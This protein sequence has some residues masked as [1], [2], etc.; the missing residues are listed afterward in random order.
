MNKVTGKALSL[1]L[2]LALVVSSFPA[3][4][5]SAST[6]TAYGIVDNTTNDSIYMVNGGSGNALKSPELNETWIKPSLQTNTRDDA[7]D[8]KVTAISHVS[9]D[10]LVSLD[11]ENNRD[12][13]YLKLKSKSVK[14][15]EVIAILYKATY[16]DEDGNDYTIKARKNFTVYVLDKNAP[17][18]G[19]V[20][21]STNPSK[22]PDDGKGLDDFETFAQTRNT[23]KTV[24]LY[25]AEPANDDP[26]NGNAEATFKPITVT[27]DKKGV[28][29]DKNEDV[30]DSCYYLEI[31]DGKNDLHFADANLTDLADKDVAWPTQPKSG[32]KDQLSGLY[33]LN[34]DANPF[35]VVS[36]KDL[37]NKDADYG[38][39]NVFTE[40]AGTSNVT[41]TLKKL[42]SDGTV[43][44]S[45]SDK[46]T[47]KTKIEKKVN[48]A[49]VYKNAGKSVPSTFTV[50]KSDGQ[51]RLDGV[52]D[53]LSS[54]GKN[55]KYVKVTD[56]ILDF[57]KGTESVSVGDDTDTTNTKSIVGYVGELTIGED[58]HVGTIDIKDGTVDVSGK[59]GDITTDDKSYDAGSNAT[60]GSVKIEST[61][62][63]GAIDTT[64]ADTSTDEG[65]VTIN[66]GTVGDVTTKSTVSIDGQDSD[67]NI[68]TGIVT[69]NGGTIYSDEAK[70]SIGGL[71]AKSDDGTF[72]L[73]GDNVAVKSVDLDSRNTTLQLGS[74]DEDDE[75]FTGTIPQ[76]KNATNA[77]IK[78][79]NDGT[80]A[81]IKSDLNVDTIDM[82]SD[83]Q[84]TLA[85]NNQAKTIEGDG[86]LTIPAGKLYVTE[87][88]SSTKLKLS[89]KNIAVGTTVFKAKSD[90]VSEDD[91]DCYGFTVTKKAGNTVDTFNVASLKFAGMQISGGP[92]QL[93]VGQSGTYTASAYPTGTTVPTGY[94]VE[95]DLDGGS[96]DVFALTS[97]GNT[98]TVKVNS[99]DTTFASENKT[100]LTATLYDQDGYEDD[101]Y[102][103]ATFDIAA[104]STPAFQSDTHGNVNVAQG[105]TYQFKIT[106]SDGSQPT[107]TV[108]GA[109]FTYYTVGKSGNDYFFKVTPSKTSKVG[110]CVGVYVN[111]QRIATAT[112][113]APAFTID[114]GKTLSLSVGKAYTFKVTASS[115]PSFTSANSSVAKSVS[116]SVSGN[117]Y[118]F[119]IQGVHAGTV[120]IYVDGVRCTV[121][122]VK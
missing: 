99:L 95:W 24:G 91:F 7:D 97:T 55:N 71:K 110:D 41:F 56:A 29:P 116:S 120:G 16:T 94:T 109:A 49:Q 9:G 73:E 27:T 84:L 69:A 96:S 68:T 54:D 118:Y 76:I 72:V 28:V 92:S 18:F 107:F 67:D 33:T 101:D 122:T 114:T 8:A 65:Q 22:A 37:A 12:D 104:V 77:T 47:F 26:K 105:K 36:G 93:V 64:D 63:A 83:T 62:T 70:V 11:L 75:A 6:R 60:D 82:D 2:S 21:D 111:G 90:A 4:L 115:K 58:A 31:T 78:T 74:E 44:S 121:V 112:V 89:D 79:E 80:N 45:S 14:G 23:V 66:G 20:K 106:V 1:V 50:K 103:P 43:S 61:A 34:T 5:A 81:T 42:K 53:S 113:A 59:V 86:I 40:D 88:A 10:S 48:V 100:S 13:A 19:E 39:S 119:K 17:V 46:Y 98:A 30:K 35:Q 117:N 85:G 51:T 3:I 102:A 52:M 87:S 38:A 57:P 108:G 32:D 15:T 25:V